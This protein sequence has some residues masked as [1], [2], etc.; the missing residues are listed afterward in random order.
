[1]TVSVYDMHT[2]PIESEN[3]A[4]VDTGSTEQRDL[5]LWLTLENFAIEYSAVPNYSHQRGRGDAVHIA[6]AP[7]HSP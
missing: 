6:P 2:L 1:M 4:R 3:K 5:K 7:S